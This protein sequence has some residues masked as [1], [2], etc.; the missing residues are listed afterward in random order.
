[1][2]FPEWKNEWQKYKIQTLGWKKE[3]C[4]KKPQII[5]GTELGQS[6]KNYSN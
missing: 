2:Q 3:E 1:M 6:I 4:Q 5:S